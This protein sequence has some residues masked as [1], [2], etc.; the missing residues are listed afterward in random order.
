MRLRD[1]LDPGRAEAIGELKALLT[2]LFGPIPDGSLDALLDA[3]MRASRG[4]PAAAGRATL[5]VSPLR[6]LST[7][8]TNEILASHG[9]VV[10]AVDFT[11]VPATPG[12]TPLGREGVVIDQVRRD[13]EFAIARLR[14][15]PNVRPGRFGVFGFSG[16]GIAALALA[17]ARS[18]VG[19]V[20]LFETGWYGPLGSSLSG[21]PQFDLGK[22]TAPLLFTWSDALDFAGPQ[23]RDIEEVMSNSSRTLARGSAAGL[24]HWDFASEGYLAAADGHWRAADR[25]GVRQ[26]FADAN[27]MLVAFF[28][29]HLRGRETPLPAGRFTVRTL[30][31]ATR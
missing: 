2:R 27:A 1:H 23:L 28:D 19:G 8:H 16:A 21:I 7:S 22:I 26:L 30:P 15:E 31:P 3:P 29:R 4:A 10:A 17:A 13:L 25:E 6:E 18:D 20:A 11:R 14:R 5:I 9:F 12:A 24:S